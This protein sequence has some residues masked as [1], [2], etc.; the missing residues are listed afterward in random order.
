MQTYFK[1][2]TSTFKRIITHTHTQ[3]CWEEPYATKVSDQQERKI[4]IWNRGSM[5]G[6]RGRNRH[7]YAH[8]DCLL[9]NFSFSDLNWGNLMPEEFSER[10]L[11]WLCPFQENAKVLLS[12]LFSRQFLKKYTLLAII[13]FYLLQFLNQVLQKLN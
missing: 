13:Q 4:T 11:L 3:N 1:Q 12:C 2:N 6:I 7:I 10:Y 8:L 5:Y 9:L